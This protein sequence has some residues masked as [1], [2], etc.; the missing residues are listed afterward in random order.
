M[1]SESSLPI[2]PVCVSLNRSDLRS[3][4]R[5][6]HLLFRLSQSRGYRELVYPQLA[7]VARFDPGHASLMMGY[8]F[9]LSETGPKLIEVN[10]NAG[11]AY[12]A[13]LSE[14]QV[15]KLTPLILPPHFD[16]RLLDSFLREWRD[17]SN[18][19]RSLERVVIMDDDPVNQPLYSEMKACRDWLCNKGID[20]RIAAPEQLEH[21]ADGVYLQG[22][23]IDLIYNRHCDFFLEE[24]S[25]AE[26][27][28]SYL[29]AKVCLSPNPFAYGLLAD[30]RRM[31]LWSNPETMSRL[32]LTE[33]E[34]ALLK[35]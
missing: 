35:R 2:S 28:L 1:S 17:F 21:C 15:D 13:W 20:A 6:V 16:Q 29:A 33:K 7:D 34:R 3:M 31:I 4:M 23:K 24:E 11:G 32:D 22:E 10:T 8:D 27:R 25:M 30:K 9:H 19:E 14:Q 26:L 5:L 18:T 12:L